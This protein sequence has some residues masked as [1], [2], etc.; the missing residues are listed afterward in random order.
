MS[1]ETWISFGRCGTD[2]LQEG[3][4]KG[5]IDPLNEEAICPIEEEAFDQVEEEAFDPVKEEAF[6]PVE[7]EDPAEQTYPLQTV[8]R[9]IFFDNGENKI[10]KGHLVAYELLGPSNQY[11]YKCVYEDGDWESLRPEA[12]SQLLEEED[13]LEDTVRHLNTCDDSS[14]ADDTGSAFE[15]SK[16]EDESAYDSSDARQDAKQRYKKR[17]PKS[18]TT[19]PDKRHKKESAPT[20]TT[21]SD[22][23]HRKKSPPKSPTNPDKRR[24]K[25]RPVVSPATPDKRREQERTAKLPATPYSQT[26]LPDLWGSPIIR[27]PSTCKVVAA[28]RLDASDDESEE[29]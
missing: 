20:S 2:L 14:T 27:S 9:K 6:D 7:E 12:V 18:T 4:S 8:V 11:W 13:S 17:A 3:S 28:R 21:T 22:S 29:E 26:T 10:Y 25:D 1:D 23:C 24:K 5:N 16:S 15:D 19:S